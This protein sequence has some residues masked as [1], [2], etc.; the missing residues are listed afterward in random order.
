MHLH[1][2]FETRSKLDLKKVG[3]EKYARHPSTK[4]LM[5]AFAVNNH[6]VHQ[7]FP[8]LGPMPE[9]LRQL[10]D[11][12]T[13]EIIAENA[14]FE[15]AIFLHVLGIDIPL[16][17]FI[18]TQAM[19]LSLA[20]PQDLDTRM[21]VL[22]VDA[23][24]QKN[25]RGKALIK[26]F[27]E[28]NRKTKNRPQDWND[29]TTHPVEWEEFCEYNRT[30]IVAERKGFDILLRYLPDLDGMRKLWCMC[31][32]INER[33]VP[34]DMEVVHGAIKVAERAKE[35]FYA[36][37]QEITGLDNPNS[38]KQILAW[39]QERGYPYSNLRKERVGMAL[40][41]DIRKA[42][43]ANITPEALKLL[44]LRQ[45]SAKTSATKLDAIVRA[46]VEGWLYQMFQFRAASRTGRYGGRIVQLQNLARPHKQVEKFLAEAREILRDADYE[47]CAA[48]FDNPLDVVTSCIRSVIAPPPGKKLVVA[49]LAAIELAVLA[50]LTG[51]KFWLDVLREGRDPY[52]SFGVHFLNKP[53]DEITKK[54]RN[55]CKPGALGA[56]YRLG[57]GFLSTD[58]NGDITKT[59][60]WGYAESLGAKLTKEQAHRAVEVYREISPE[61]VNFWYELEQ[62]TLAT[63]RDKKP[64][65]VRGLL[66]DIREPFLRIR[67]PSGRRLHYCR[68]KIEKRK[69]RS[70]TNDDGTPKFFEAIN[71]T[72]EGMDQTTKQWVRQATHGGKQTENVVQAIALD[73]LNYGIEQA[74]MEG[75]ETILHV[76][77]ENGT[78]CDEDDTDHGLP[79]L[80]ECITRKPTWAKDLPLSAAGYEG[81][82]YRKD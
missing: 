40:D 16:E 20:L 31:Q 63:I 36:Q 14:A 29:W 80:I 73:I 17:R 60:L 56:G 2:D 81:N 8:H 46:E 43:K 65:T 19:G 23:K 26:L 77:D 66:I 67:L 47:M 49:D 37:M 71:F 50:W 13:V 75:F 55:D 57:G 69:V 3:V 38:P 62:A 59:G 7:W 33:G 52:K 41:A 4:V 44:K 32:R 6:D 76:H 82:F 24:F 61:V 5:L 39:L 58:K 54:E 70:G 45:E 64:R 28:P 74:E 79:Q 11:N 30:D 51:S 48:I 1:S 68:P 27:C 12:P 35:V 53:Y 21:R 42:V 22:R 15:R 18:C 72:Y 9:K 25:S 78:M 10:L 34:V